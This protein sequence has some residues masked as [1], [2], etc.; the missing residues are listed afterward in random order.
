MQWLGG[1]ESRTKAKVWS[2]API[3]MDERSDPTRGIDGA[4]TGDRTG[5]MRY[6]DIEVKAR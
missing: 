2:I 5:R 1:S 6:H 4:A 3:H